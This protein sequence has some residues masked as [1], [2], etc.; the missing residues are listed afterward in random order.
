MCPRREPETGPLPIPSPTWD[1]EGKREAS[2]LSGLSFARPALRRIH[3]IR[4]L[5]ISPWSQA[6]SSAGPGESGAEELD[7]D[8]AGLDPF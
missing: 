2:A 6:R 4:E 5:D 3:I 7:V 1:E 8:G